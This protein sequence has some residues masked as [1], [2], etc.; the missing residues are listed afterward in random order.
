MF[1]KENPYLQTIGLQLYTLRDQLEQDAEGTLRALA[2]MGY[3]QVELMDTRQ[4]AK[5]KPI[6][7][8][9]GLAV[10]SSFLLWTTITGN[11]DVVPH[12]KDQSFSFEKVL[13]QANS[14]KLDHL[15][16]GYMMKEERSTIDQYK[17]YCD[18]LNEAGA[19]A[20]A[21]GIQLCYH[22]HSFEFGAIDGVIPFDV[23]TERLDPE[24]VPFELDVFWVS[25]GGQDPIAMM[26]KLRGRI[27]LLHLKNK[28]QGMPTNYDEAAVPK[29]AFRE[30]GNGVINIPAI[31][32]KAEEIGVKYCFVEQDQSPDPI[33]SV[34][35]SISFAKERF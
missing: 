27:R 34:G 28:K 21:A 9:L 1:E 8:D 12:E 10:H 16:F 22:N 29:E 6:A 31:V 5:L 4:I 15:V 32:K 2:D 11:W 23:L 24:L 35:E 13:E 17:R 25:I 7:D 26:E 33:N 19:K 14:A 3:Q 18:L 20:K 30:L